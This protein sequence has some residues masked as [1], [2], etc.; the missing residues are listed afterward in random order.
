MRNRIGNDRIG[1]ISYSAI[2]CCWL[3]LEGIPAFFRYALQQR[4]TTKMITDKNVIMTH[5]PLRVVIIISSMAVGLVKL[6][7]LTVVVNIV[8]CKHQ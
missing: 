7:F 4:M 3:N 5:A 2:L 1:I 6:G 8:N